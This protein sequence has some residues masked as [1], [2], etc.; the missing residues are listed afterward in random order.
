[1]RAALLADPTTTACRLF[2]GA[3]DGIDGLVIERLGAALVVQLHEERLSLDERSVRELCEQAAAKVGATAVYRKVFPRDRSTALA[4][5]AQ[6][7]TDPTPWIGKPTEAEFAVLEN[8]LRLLVRPYDG[9]STGLF[10]EHRAN[11]ERLREL[12]AGRRVLNAFAYTCGFT[13]AAGIGGAAMTVSVDVSRKFLEWGKRNLGA[14]G[15]PLDDHRFICSDVFD[16]YRRARRQGHRFDLIVL[17]PPTFSRTKNPRRVFSVT[18][19]LDRLVADAVGLLEPDGR[20]LLCTNHRATPIGDLER[21]AASVAGGRRYEVIAR[22][23]LPED[24]RGDPDYA[25]SLLVRIG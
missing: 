16:Y 2:N 5:V 6:L 20:L 19:D 3:A 7:H 15:L 18:E 24:F 17:D 13:V 22:P 21:A 8:G 12:A 14:N 23:E 1:M 10:L 11:R 4:R 25:K 9:Y